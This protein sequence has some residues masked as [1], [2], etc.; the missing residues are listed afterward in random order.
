MP[1][2][3]NES[4]SKAIHFADV[5]EANKIKSEYGSVVTP[6][7]REQATSTLQSAVRGYLKVKAAKK[8]LAKADTDD[9]TKAASRQHYW[10]AKDERNKLKQMIKLEEPSDITPNDAFNTKL[11][12]AI[13]NNQYHLIDYTYKDFTPRLLAALRLGLITMN[14][15]LSVKLMYESLLCFNKGTMPDNPAEMFRRFKISDPKG[16][17]QPAKDISYWTQAETEQLKAELL[18]P[19]A[20]EAHHYYTINLPHHQT[21]YFFYA[22][23]E[24][25]I[26][27]PHFINMFSAYI[28]GLPI[29][30]AEKNRAKYTLETYKNKPNKA[31]KSNLQKFIRTHE[32]SVHNFLLGIHDSSTPYNPQNLGLNCAEFNREWRTVKFWV[33]LYDVSCQIPSVCLPPEDVRPGAEQPLVSFVLPTIDTLNMLQTI[34]HGEEATL[35]AAVVGKETPRMIRAYDEIPA[36]TMKG[37]ELTPAEILL[38]TLYP[39]AATLKG[40]SRPIELTCSGIE[41]TSQPHG[42]VC[43]DFF[44]SWHDLFHTW[45]NGSNFKELIRH[46]RK[47]HDQKSG[48]FEGVDAMSKVIWGLSDMDMSAGAVFREEPNGL[49]INV[50]CFVTIL[51]QSG[52]NFNKPIDDNYLMIYSLC[53]SPDSWGKPFGIDPQALAKSSRPGSTCE[54]ETQFVAFIRQVDN[55]KSYLKDHPKATVVEVILHDLLKPAEKMDSALLAEVN[56]LG[57]KNLFY[58]SRNTG[59]YFKEE[60][61]ADLKKLG[62][63]PN[64]R[65]NSPALIRIALK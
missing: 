29:L 48:F 22:C 9:L 51:E 32:P 15:L 34:V 5:R 55:M 52:F 49:Y 25:G 18:K 57:L 38:Q 4:G 30:P 53:Q 54:S 60:F 20:D 36:S 23:L 62:I 42:A 14:Q 43:H 65:K 31:N 45:R 35:P 47:L 7:Y 46:F 12:Q 59:L 41:K 21:V 6:Y 3:R 39:T 27:N 1:G 37:R 17:Y 61:R 16:P 8:E 58:W 10:A 44:L 11:V 13:K 50:L 28:E 2:K 24:D 40:P 26:Y 19:G 64:L 63:A 56:K 33:Y